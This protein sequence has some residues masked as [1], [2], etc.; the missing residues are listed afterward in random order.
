MLFL[1]FGSISGH[2]HQRICILATNGN[3]PRHACLF[4]G[5]VK[6]CYC[7]HKSLFKYKRLEALPMPLETYAS[8]N[9]QLVVATLAWFESHEASVTTCQTDTTVM[10]STAS[11]CTICV[12]TAHSE[13]ELL[14]ASSAR[15]LNHT[16]ACS[17]T[18]IKKV[19][20]GVGVSQ[21]PR[22]P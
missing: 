5:T 1:V 8:I 3:C 9:S 7:L 20:W 10:S 18:V 22:N 19:G 2:D 14:N 11:L 13:H 17:S 21:V 15:S 6:A 16:N 12:H 4:F